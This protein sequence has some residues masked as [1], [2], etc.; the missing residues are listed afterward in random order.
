MFEKPCEQDRKHTTQPRIIKPST[1][2]CHGE[3][4]NPFDFQGQRSRSQWTILEKPC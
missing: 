4:M 3:M 2:C 1:N